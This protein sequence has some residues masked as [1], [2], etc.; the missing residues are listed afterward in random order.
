MLPLRVRAIKCIRRSSWLHHYLSLTSDCLVSYQGHSLGKTYPSVEMQSVYST[1]PEDRASNF[2][3]LWI[4]IYE[5]FQKK[6]IV[7][8]ATN[9]RRK[10]FTRYLFIIYIFRTTVVIFVA[11]F[12][13]TFR[14]LYAPA[15]FR[16]LECRTWPF[17]SLI[18]ADCCSSTR[19]V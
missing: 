19:H 6:A 14:S 1:A 3:R 15:V 18:W 8:R 10:N 9:V 17:I 4:Y 16:W 7:W 2:I 13:T 12:I 5:T 11:M